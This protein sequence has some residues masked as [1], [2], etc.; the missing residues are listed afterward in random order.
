[1]TISDAGTQSLYP[2]AEVEP[3]IGGNES[4]SLYP[5]AKV[6]PEI[7]EHYATVVVATAEMTPIHE[8]IPETTIAT[9]IATLP[10]NAAVPIHLQEKM[11]SKCCGACCD[12]RRAVIIMTGIYIGFG[13]FYIIGLSGDDVNGIY[14]DDEFVD[15]VSE[16]RGEYSTKAS[17]FLS[18]ALITNVIAMVG[19]VHFNIWMVGLH[20]VWMVL[21]YISLV[22]LTVKRDSDLEEPYESADL[23]LASS[24]PGF[25]INGLFTALFMYPLLGFITEVR[26]GILTRETYAREEFSC[27]CTSRRS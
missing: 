16:I 15:E 24:V 14:G 6:E 13:V 26:A 2:S 18:V 9:T 4:Q 11:G 17:I 25:V 20:T 21:V 7:G 3:E 8:L 12:Y 22:I 1:M 23:E 19:A 10:Q 5:S 27:C